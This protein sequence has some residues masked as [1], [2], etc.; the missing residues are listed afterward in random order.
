MCSS[1]YANAAK[2]LNA[3]VCFLPCSSDHSKLH[4]S[5]L[6]P[7]TTRFN[8]VPKFTPN[9]NSQR[10][11][12]HLNHNHKTIVAC[13]VYRLFHVYTGWPNLVDVIKNVL[14]VPVNDITFG[15]VALCKIERIS[16]LL[17]ESVCIACIW[18]YFG[19][20]PDIFW[21]NAYCKAGLGLNFVHCD[22]SFVDAS[23]GK[24]DFVFCH[25]KKKIWLRMKTQ[26]S[27]CR[28]EPEV[29]EF[30]SKGKVFKFKIIMFGF[31]FI[32]FEFECFVILLFKFQKN[33]DT[34]ALKFQQ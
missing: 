10:G 14:P 23:M 4:D 34:L 7:R 9:A 31:R 33:F 16:I 18:G 22:F 6:L 27:F 3:L 11:T 20:R 30:F 8:F 1:C 28:R 17:D 5:P 13:S 12:Q 21:C 19:A 25:F 24:K 15:E 29:D 32:N 2:C 26:W